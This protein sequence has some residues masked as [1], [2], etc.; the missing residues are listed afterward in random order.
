M[1]KEH[2]N[3]KKRGFAVPHILVI[4]SVIILLCCLC[5][6]IAP[7][8]AFDLDESGRVIPGTFHAV[9]RVTISPWA[10]LLMVMEGVQNA[11]TVIALML[12]A[13]GAIECVISTGAFTDI[14]NYGVYRLKDKS[15]EV[16]VPS[17][18]VLMSAVGA[19]AA[20]DSLIAF[21]AVGIIIC[22]R[23]RLDRI[24]AMAMFYLGYLIGQA[25]SFT[26]SMVII[27]Q[28]YA[29]VPPLSG[30]GVR[31]FIWVIFTAVNAAYC[32]RYALRISRDPSKSYMGE[33]LEPDEHM[34]E[35]S[36]AAFPLR[37]VLV[38]IGMFGI[39][40]CYSICGRT[41]GWGMQHL[42]ALFIIM[43]VL[44]SVIYGVNANNAGKAF[45]KGA[46]SMGG[47]CLVMGL[48]RV[49]GFVLQR[50]NIMH[51]LSHTV[52][53]IIGGSGL[54]IAA[55]G[56]FVFTLLLNFVIPS[57][58]SK[59]AIMMPVL[60]PI[61]DLC[62]LTRQCVALAYQL[63]DG[64][65][66]TLTPMSGPLIGSLGLAN[67]NYNQWV[68]YAAPLMCILSAISA[69]FICVLSVMGWMG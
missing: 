28:G 48:A 27:F 35:I 67:V 23:L 68:K 30:M 10:A 45:F 43:S 47:I 44:V 22:K 51:T 59:A 3:G 41:L 26:S 37:G 46:C 52:S 36:S 15:V 12:V 55:V 53:G 11:S 63:G 61:G 57:G 7:T 40:I 21:V 33:V 6:Y 2:T 69:V 60:T 31:L 5:T 8:G 14:L 24:M 13:G 50:G 29:E 56:I 34:G 65:T 54:A 16:L 17:I 42:I 9:D 4:I 20:N 64:M 38:V 18:I 49:V 62:G 66:N 19:F 32:T 1:G 25:A 58:T 39:F